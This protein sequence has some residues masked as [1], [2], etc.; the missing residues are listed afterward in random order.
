MLSRLG[1][2]ALLLSLL[3]TGCGGGDPVGSA[4][5]T[6]TASQS[7][8]TP[9][10]TPTEGATVEPSISTC[11]LELR[12]VSRVLG[13]TWE[14]E[15][16]SEGNCQYTSD[17]GA[18]FGT[19]PV[20]GEVESGLA[21]ARKACLKGLPPLRVGGG[22]VCVERRPPTR[23]LVVGNIAIDDQLWVVIITPQSQGVPE[24]EIR[25]MAALLD[26]VAD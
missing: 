20:E 25:A 11:M 24:A 23:D 22:F 4:D 9:T 1:P 17:R 19:E 15:P 21:E 2:L 10:G 3:A 14:R 26:I 12:E 5:P 18:V 16:T 7:T 6:P 8:G 13:G